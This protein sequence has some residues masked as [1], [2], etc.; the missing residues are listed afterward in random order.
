[1]PVCKRMPLI[2]GGWWLGLIYQLRIFSV[3]EEYRLATMHRKPQVMIRQRFR[4][5]LLAQR[6][7]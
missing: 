6:E 5:R 1:M 2:E 4:R 7:Q 3:L